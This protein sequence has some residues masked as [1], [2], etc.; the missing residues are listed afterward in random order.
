ME[1][2]DYN[3]IKM[4]K[5][6]LSEQLKPKQKRLIFK[7]R[8]RMAE[9]GENYR[10]GR[11]QVMCPLCETHLDNQ[12]LSYQCLEIRS[13][14][15]IMGKIEDIF[16]EEISLETAETIEKITELRRSWLEK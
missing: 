14:L 1:K 10:G 9:F 12:E 3:E 4:Q 8:T 7:Y 6:L 13:K 2:L 16:K 15:K 11:S 5:Y